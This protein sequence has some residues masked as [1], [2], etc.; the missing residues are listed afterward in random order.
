MRRR[1]SRRWR[2]K[3]MR[4]WGRRRRRRRSRRR[5]ETVEVVKMVDECQCLV[6]L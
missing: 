1:E 4:R 6:D 2:R 3:R 5:R